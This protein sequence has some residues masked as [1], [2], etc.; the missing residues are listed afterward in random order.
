M[1]E[2]I[3]VEDK[4]YKTRTDILCIYGHRHCLSSMSEVGRG[5]WGGRRVKKGEC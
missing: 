1:C 3:K 4:I 5:E 2:N